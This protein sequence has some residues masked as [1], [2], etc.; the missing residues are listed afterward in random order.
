M[1]E[2]KFSRIN[3]NVLAEITHK[4]GRFTAAVQNLSLNGIFVETATILPK[5]EIVS[6]KIRLSSLNADSMVNLA[7][8]VV[9]SDEKGIAFQ[10]EKVELDS[11]IFLRNIMIYNSGDSEKIDKEYHEFL[12]WNSTQK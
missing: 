11:F 7:A 5:D 8:K 10:F 3:F 6:L 12:K 1:T 9:R 2:R 4:E